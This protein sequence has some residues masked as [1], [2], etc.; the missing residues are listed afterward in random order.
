[1]AVYFPRGQQPFGKIKQKFVTDFRGVRGNSADGMV[2]VT[3]QVL[4]LEERRQL[5]E[6]VDGGVTEIYHLERL[7]AVLDQP[8][9]AA[10]RSQFLSIDAHPAVES[11]YVPVRRLF[12]D[13]PDVVEISGREREL[14]EL[15]GFLR[16]RPQ[17]AVTGIITGMAGAGKTALADRAAADA[18]INGWFPG[19]VLRIDFGEDPVPAHYVVSSVLYALDESAVVGETSMVGIRYHDTLRMLASV[20]SRVLLILDNVTDPAQV[21][22][23]IPREPAHRALMTS[24]NALGPKVDAAFDIRIGA[25]PREHSVEILGMKSR[26]STSDA[27]DELATLCGDLPLAL[28][29]VAAII[30]AEPEAPIEDLVAELSD[31]TSRLSGLRFAGLAVTSAL[32]LSC[33]RL[34]DDSA[35]C[36]RLLSLHLGKEFAAGAMASL[37]DTT[38]ARARQL[39]RSLVHASL[40]EPGSS[41][42]RWKTH[43]LVR[44]YSAERCDTE[45]E[46]AEVQGAKARLIGYYFKAAVQ[47]SQWLDDTPETDDDPAQPAFCNHDDALNWFRHEI[48]NLV[49]SVYQALDGGHYAEAWD[50]GMAA[51]KYLSLRWDYQPALP[52]FNA[53]LTAAREMHDADLETGALNSLGLTFAFLGDHDEAMRTF[54]TGLRRAREVGDRRTEA[55]LLTGVAD[56]LRKRGD[57]IAGLGP[58]RRAVRL[59]EQVKDA[60]GL[61]FHLT[62]LGSCLREAGQLA[63]A[64]QVLRRALSVHRATGVKRAEGATMA[65]LGTTLFQI[66]DD[67]EAE[68]LLRGAIDLAAEVGDFNNRAMMVLN[69]ANI[70]LRRREPTAA[71]RFY[72]ES[73]A[74]FQEHGDRANEAMALANIAEAH[75]QLGQTGLAERAIQRRHELNG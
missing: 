57:H 51:G 3:N 39:V 64:A 19:G 7:V 66:G 1:M 42:G 6:T 62:N 52:M 31:K 2:F 61:G 56:L 21:L 11:A 72:E 45:G 34:D 20:G 26:A 33:A 44:L 35:R 27:L 47:A 48:D 65:Q 15:A 10:V 58:L 69:L 28:Q 9:M 50:L 41:T 18:A 54:K 32:Q 75:R 13:S 70:Y 68:E 12:P 8:S 46:P 43:D 29:I 37:L 17:A 14:A 24:R 53:A 30:R 63:E 23:L 59:S 74:V 22:P 25:L 38:E 71:L 60:R 4:T 67:P 5:C 36:F 73:V 40:V 16:D 49:P 55:Q